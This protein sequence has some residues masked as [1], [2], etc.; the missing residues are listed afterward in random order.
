STKSALWN[1]MQADVYGKPVQILQVSE[2]TALGAAI[3]GGIGVGIFA[4]VFQGTEQMVQITKEFQPDSKNSQIY[5]ELYD[6]YVSAYQSLTAGK[7]FNK[8]S[9]LQ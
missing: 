8:L 6:I 1:Q 9:A 5:N 3:L 4:D 2:V 7:V